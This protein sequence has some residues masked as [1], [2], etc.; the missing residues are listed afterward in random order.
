[1]FVYCVYCV[2]CLVS[3]VSFVMCV[4]VF[5]VRARAP[6]RKRDN[7]RETKEEEGVYVCVCLCVSL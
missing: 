2:L 3:C 5:C 4:C 6:V 1:M 7:V